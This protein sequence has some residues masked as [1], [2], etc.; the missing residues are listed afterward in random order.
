MRRIAALVLLL[1]AQAASSGVPCEELVDTDVPEEWAPAARLAAVE[2]RLAAHALLQ[3]WWDGSAGGAAA[4]GP[5]T[6]SPDADVL[7]LGACTKED[8]TA[9]LLFAQYSCNQQAY[10]IKL[11]GTARRMPGKD[12]RP[13]QVA[14]VEVAPSSGTVQQPAATRRLAAVDSV[15]RNGKAYARANFDA[16]GPGS[17][18]YQALLAKTNNEAAQAAFLM[19]YSQIEAGISAACPL[20]KTGGKVD[21]GALQADVMTLCRKKPEAEDSGTYYGLRFTAYLPCV[22]AQGRFAVLE[23]IVLQPEPRYTAAYEVQEVTAT[24][25]TASADGVGWGADIGI[26]NRLRV[27]VN[28]TRVS[29]LVP[30]DIAVDPSDPTNVWV[31][32][33]ENKSVTSAACGKPS[34]GPL[35]KWDSAASKFAAVPGISAAGYRVAVMPET[36]MPWI[37]NGCGQLRG[38]TASKKSL[39]GPSPQ[40]NTFYDIAAVNGTDPTYGRRFRAANSLPGLPAVMQSDGQCRLKTCMDIEPNCA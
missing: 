7:V 4:C 12:P 11:I 27:A 9:V 31:V 30:L 3:R 1:C 34:G 21:L 37:V 10:G 29:S 15:T 19:W 33:P 23:A 40:T 28:F 17:T 5:L 26:S 16:T 36:H 8:M 13:G 20:V 24:D 2:M 39:F 14:E 6:A 22:Q 25:S 32:G 35:L 38:W 18:S